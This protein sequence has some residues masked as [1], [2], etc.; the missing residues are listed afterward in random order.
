MKQLWDLLEA[1]LGANF[2]ED[3]ELQEDV[4]ELSLAFTTERSDLPRDYF[5]SPELQTAYLAYFVPL[6]FEKIYMI[7]SSHAGVWEK[8]LDAAKTLHWVDLGCGPGTA[9]LA[10]LAALKN[11][12]KK[13]DRLPLVRIDLVD[14]QTSALN[15]ADNLVREFAETLGIE[16]ETGLYTSMPEGQTYDLSLAA[17]VLNELPAEEGPMGRETLLR[18]WD[19]TQ[20][21][22][23]VLEPG[24]RV[25]SQR[26]VRF[27]ERLIKADRPHV[28]ILGPC[29][30]SERCPVHRTKHWCHFSEPV[31]DGRLIDLNLRIFK[32]P[33]GWLKFSYLLIRKGDEMPKFAGEAYRAIGDL[34]MS[35]PKRLAIDL[36]Q[37]SEKF[38]LFVP[39]NIPPDLRARLVRGAVVKLD[40][41]RQVTAKAMTKRETR[42]NIEK[43]GTARREDDRSAEQ[44]RPKKKI[45]D[46]TIARRKKKPHRY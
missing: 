24:H 18:L 38:V 15:L 5:E 36:C 22:L 3:R 13:L 1:N 26:L 9:T 32:D 35:G 16:I 14:T 8:E 11:R 39:N 19:A 37:P 7:L 31:T 6:N 25:S 44:G 12:Y 27:R 21:V 33:R 28:S 46:Q 2:A 42:P 40:E 4:R 30:H 29:I 23:L 43:R 20:G 17:N 10:A 45:S 34:H 41:D